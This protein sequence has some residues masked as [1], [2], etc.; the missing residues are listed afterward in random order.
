[1]C[2][3]VRVC[4]C[5]CVW[6]CDF[7]CVYVFVLMFTHYIFLES[8]C[9]CVLEDSEQQNNNIT[10]LMIIYLHFIS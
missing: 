9:L 10:K 1:M 8:A 5:L 7:V 6:L 3:F 2:V 4:A